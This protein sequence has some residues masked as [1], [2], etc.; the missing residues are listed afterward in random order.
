MISKK[1]DFEQI[2]EYRRK[3]GS[4]LRARAI[5]I[6][7]NKRMVKTFLTYKRSTRRKKVYTS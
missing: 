3:N 1:Q 7:Q 4:I 2:Y 5:H 6:E